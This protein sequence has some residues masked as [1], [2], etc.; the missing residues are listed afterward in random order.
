M[1]RSGKVVN[2]K[3]RRLVKLALRDAAA[4]PAG[5]KEGLRLQPLDLG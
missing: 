2:L 3:A 1:E 5:P 4:G